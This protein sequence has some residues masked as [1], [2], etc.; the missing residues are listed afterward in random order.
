MTTLLEN[1][2]HL[3][4]LAGM[5][6]LDESSDLAKRVKSAQ[7]ALYE[8]ED[9]HGQLL[10]CSKGQELKGDLSNFL[11][12]LNDAAVG[13]LRDLVLNSPDNFGIDD[14]G[15]KEFDKF[16]N[17]WVSE[18]VVTKKD[19]IVTVNLDLDDLGGSSDNLE[20]LI[21]DTKGKFVKLKNH[22]DDYEKAFEQ[23]NDVWKCVE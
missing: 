22:V 6:P 17:L 15:E 18:I 3:R 10:A 16:A 7:R 2:N 5:L 20:N 8:S 23:Q 19:F 4:K 11:S 13:K 12:K 1:L 14:C 9:I 21:F